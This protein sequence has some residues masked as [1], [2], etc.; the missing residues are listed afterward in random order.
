MGRFLVVLALL[1]GPSLAEAAPY[2]N[3]AE[4]VDATTLVADDFQH[5]GSGGTPGTWY[6]N[7]GDHSTSADKG[8]FGTIF[9]NPIT[10]AGAIVC[11]AGVSPFGLCATTGG[12]K[13]SGGT[14]NSAQHRLKTSTCGTDGTQFCNVD[15][16]YVRWYM[17]W[18]PGYIFGNEK[19]MTITNSDGDIAFITLLAHCD[20]GGTSTTASLNTP[21]NYGSFPGSANCQPQNVGN[22]ITVQSGRWYFFE[23]HVRAGSNAIIEM[24]VNDC[25]V[26]PANPNTA[27]GAAPVLRS[28]YINGTL[29]GN[30]TGGPHI[31]TLWME[32]WTQDSSTGHQS[33]GTG[34]YRNL[35]MVKST[36]PI[37]F[38]GAGTPPPTAF[39]LALASRAFAL[40]GSTAVLTQ[41]AGPTLIG[42]VHRA[43]IL[44]T[45]VALL[46]LIR[47]RIHAH[48]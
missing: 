47:R 15:E 17:K 30:S 14:K 4:P 31:Q 46:I 22:N 16:I 35:L 34:P 11:G 19:D 44:V 24:W 36:G 26:A 2:F 23:L 33:Q 42:F 18:D 13:P 32:T 10:P 9:N 41:I 25:G 8:W 12:N 5:N 1:I 45:V 37:G 27:C 29:P 7:D 39:S 43:S 38:A 3:T 40:T 21:Y 20:S 28:R 48:R 6:V